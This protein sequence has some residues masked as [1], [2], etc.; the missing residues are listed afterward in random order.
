MKFIIDAQL[1]PALAQHLVRLGHEAKHVVDVGLLGADDQ[2][3]RQYA[4]K[5]HWAIIT[6]DEDFTSSLFWQK[7]HPAVV[8]L[9]VGN[10]SNQALFHWFLPMLPKIVLRL[11]EGEKLIEIV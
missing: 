5:H 1:P 10:C 6:K 7:N 2:S 8:W 3:L 9:R 4:A 11:Q